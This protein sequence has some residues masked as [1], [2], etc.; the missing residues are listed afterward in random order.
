MDLQPAQSEPNPTSALLRLILRALFAGLGSWRIEPALTVVA[1]RRISAAFGRIERM[2]VR[3]RAGRL[4]VAPREVTARG[5]P[6]RRTAVVR[7]PRQFGWLLV[8]GKHQA[9]YVR[10][11][12]EAVLAMPDMGELLATSPQARQIL[13]PVCRSLAIALPW[14][15]VP[16]RSPT[17]RKPRPKPEPFRIPLPRGV[18]T[19]ARREKR[20]ER[21]RAE[22]NRIL[23][24]A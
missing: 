11:Q 15:V 24:R 9:A 23:G 13:R 14:T 5:R 2:L 12:L 6:A 17:P 19:W 3:F 16:P 4:P 18:I 20:I 21:A 22:M 8:A 7:L 1:Y 10:L